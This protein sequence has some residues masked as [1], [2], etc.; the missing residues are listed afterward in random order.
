M[1][2]QRVLTRTA[3]ALVDDGWMAY[4]P[5]VLARGT[6]TVTTD[7]GFAGQHTASALFLVLEWALYDAGRG[8]RLDLEAVQARQAGLQASLQDREAAYAVRQARRDL[9]TVHATGETAEQT[10]VLA[11]ETRAQVLARYRAGRATALELVEAEDTLRQAELDRI[12]RTLELYRARLA[13]FRAL[14]LDPLGK[15][16]VDP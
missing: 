4:L 10:L 14:G 8:A 2:A 9:D 16:V 6:A 5:S 3:E 13:L 11:R 1:A 15:E 12:A 7:G